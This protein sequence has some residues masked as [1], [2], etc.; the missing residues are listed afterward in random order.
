MHFLTDTL[1]FVFAAS[2]LIEAGWD[3]AQWNAEP[4]GWGHSFA[5][6]RAGYGL[7]LRQLQQAMAA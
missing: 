3:P 6:F 1:E 7:T 5:R 4:K 2:D